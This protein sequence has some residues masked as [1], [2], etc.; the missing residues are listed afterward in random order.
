MAARKKGAQPTYE[1]LAIKLTH[2]LAGRKRLKAQTDKILQILQ[3]HG[4]EL[5]QPAEE[6]P[7]I[8]K[9]LQALVLLLKDTTTHWLPSL[10]C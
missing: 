8:E 7:E 3:D 6:W 5:A 4:D 9:E 2:L 1:A 10:K